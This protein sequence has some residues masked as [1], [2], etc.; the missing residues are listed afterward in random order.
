MQKRVKL[1]PA[2]FFSQKISTKNARFATFRNSRQNSVSAFEIKNFY[3]QWLFLALLVE[4]V[5]VASV[6]IAPVLQLLEL[7]ALVL[8]APMIPE[9]ST[10]IASTSA[11][12]IR[13]S[14]T[15]AG[16]NGATRK[17][18]QCC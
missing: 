1:A 6:L 13:A 9:N 7:L 10:S 5:L 16:S 15:G 12:I 8:V 14:S 18:D 17:Y 2:N 4:P 3:A 11:N